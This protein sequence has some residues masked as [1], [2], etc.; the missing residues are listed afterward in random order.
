[1]NEWYW[2]DSWVLK[3][4]TWNHLT[5]GKQI[6]SGS[7]KNCYQQTIFYKSFFDRYE[8]TGFGIK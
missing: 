1:M 6:N 7:F 2:I 3:S 4:N 5:V 8:S